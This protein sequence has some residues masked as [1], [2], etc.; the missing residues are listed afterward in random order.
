MTQTI[1]RNTIMI[2]AGIATLFALLSGCTNVASTR[3]TSKVKL[4]NASFGTSSVVYTHSLINANV[5][6]STGTPPGLTLSLSVATG[7]ASL[8]QF[9]TVGTNGNFPC[10]CVLRWQEL[11]TVGGNNVPINRVRKVGI[12]VVQNSLVQCP[13]TQA[14]WDEIPAGAVLRMNLEAIAPNTS[15]LTVKDLGYK[16]GTSVAPTGDFVDD[17]LTPFRNIMRYTCHTKRRVA[18]EVLSQVTQTQVTENN[19]TTTV[20]VP[21]ATNFCATAND[22][23]CS[24]QM[25]MDFTAQSY[26]RNL[27]VRSDRAGQIV[28][29]NAR[30]VC[31]QVFESITS[32]ATNPVSV[33][34]SEQFDY[35]PM[36]SMFSVSTVSSNEWSVPITAASTLMKNG[37]PSDAMNAADRLQEINA[38]NSGIAWKILGFGKLPNADGTCGTIV[39]SNGLVRPLTRLR[40]YR[41][42]YPAAF[43]DAGL[44]LNERLEADQVLVPDRLVVDS[45]GK[46]TGNM[47]Y[48]PKPCNFAWFDHSGVTNR[49]H[50]ND[51]FKTPIPKGL[52]TYQATSSYYYQDSILGQPVDFAVNPDGKYLP[53]VDRKQNGSLQGASCSA[54]IAVYDEVNGLPGRARLLTSYLNRTDKITMGS[55][56]LYL[57]EI[58]L[59]PVDRW[60]PQYVEDT[61]FRACVPASDPYVEPP[62]HFYRESQ[63]AGGNVGWCA[64]VY[65]TQNPFWQDLN[66][67]KKVN[68]VSLSA[69]LVNWGS[70]NPN[71]NTAKVKWYTS[72]K[73]SSLGLDLITSDALS[74][75]NKVNACTSTAPDKICEFSLGTGSSDYNTCVGY[76]TNAISSDSAVNNRCDRTMKFDPMNEAR[77]L[78]LLA[79]DEDIQAM[80]KNDL[81]KQ[82]S[83]ACMYSVHSNPSKIGKSQPLSNCCGIKFGRSILDVTNRLIYDTPG[84]QGHLE[85]YPDPAFPA[86]RF[87]GN[88][89][90]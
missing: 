38:G 75:T 84:N 4:T 61:S 20:P 21:S 42:V 7:S 88:P 85:P 54:S 82:K 83:F 73:D 52:P 18:V 13:L 81:S 26:Y 43:T 80:L 63:A 65:P 74:G 33:P 16:K 90:E 36:D 2:A 35:W 22:Q 56:D 59:A 34:Q 28:S 31:P 11:N 69:L 9:C 12:S 44:P 64:K 1:K 53:N 40:R 6:A 49:T 17:T 77:T 14:F 8:G 67:K 27:Y 30:Y 39:D 50:T 57:K 24:S 25:R 32:K 62:L 5:V 79:R 86:S 51:E 41:V 68:Q 70:T 46:L 29:S 87:C 60:N 19:I 55:K 45:A 72:H 3:A 58:H 48:G 66:K 23:N 71:T 76:L 15:G 10:V 47:I 37:E 78:P 89:V